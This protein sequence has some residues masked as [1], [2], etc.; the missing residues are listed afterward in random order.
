MTSN[1]SDTNV[2]SP[3]QGEVVQQTV[4]S[5]VASL[6]LVNSAYDLAATAYAS[7]KESH[8]Y[9]KS[10]C[11]MAEKGVTSI[12]NVAVGSAQPVL[13]KLEPQVAEASECASERLE[14]LE[15]NLPILQQS[16]DK[17]MAETQESVSCKLSDVKETMIRMV[18][19][20]KEAMQDS[21]KTTKSVVTDSMSTVVESRMGQLAISGME[22]VLEKSEE[23]LDHYL[24]MTDDEL[25][26]LAE[27]VEGTKASS[28]QPQEHR[29]YFVRLGS[30]STKLRQRAYHHSLDKIRRTSQSITQAL[31]QLHQT[32]G[33]IEYIKQGVKLQDVQEKFHH[34][35]LNWSRQLPKDSEIKDLAKPEMESETL[36]M[37]RSIL[38]QLQ[39][40]CLMLV[41]SIQGLPTNL[42]EKVQQV[43]HNIEELHTSFSTAHSFQDL[44]SSL[45]TQSQEMVTKAQEY[46]DELMAYMVQNT[47]LSWVVGPFM[48]SGK[49][50]ADSTEPQSQDN[51]A[52][53]A[54]VLTASASKEEL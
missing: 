3:E 50:S 40:A 29:S 48:P 42:Q 53:A 41:S 24:P 16:A 5:T 4:L 21:M 52:E 23:L 37:S 8:P 31:S 17:I 10:F 19:M 54:E 39:D 45:L 32:M 13:T 11:D 34:I 43:Y 51:E 20:T 6:P 15:E 18:D 12:T 36:A 25:A 44:S 38:Q 22:A 46:V 49:V 47:P 7:T 28:A 9:V 14:K 1:G 2:A 35:W 26:K 27:S 30:L 33:L